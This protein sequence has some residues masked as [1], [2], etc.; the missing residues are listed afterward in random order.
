[1]G[2]AAGQPV[3]LC[4]HRE[5]LPGLLAAACA[6]LRAETPVGLP[7]RKGT[8]RVLHTAAGR[9]AGTERHEVAS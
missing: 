9:L 5:N 8:W 1:V 3:I 4:A 7:L 6:R 2:A